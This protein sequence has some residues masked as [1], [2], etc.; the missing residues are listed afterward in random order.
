M[1]YN[2]L[3]NTD[4]VQTLNEVVQLVFNKIAEQNRTSNF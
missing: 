3:L 2:F 1:R 4:E